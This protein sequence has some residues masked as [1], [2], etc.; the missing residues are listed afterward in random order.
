MRSAFSRIGLMLRNIN[1]GGAVFGIRS[2]QGHG[3]G[4]GHHPADERETDG[5]EAAAVGHSH[6]LALILASSM[7][8]ARLRA[9]ILA[10]ERGVVGPGLLITA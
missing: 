5:P 3:Q 10:A 2:N 8:P 9:L 1:L 6:L 4:N 7:R